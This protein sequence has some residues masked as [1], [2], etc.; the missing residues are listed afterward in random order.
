MCNN[1]LVKVVTRIYRSADFGV[2][3]LK[4]LEAMSIMG[5]IEAGSS[6]DT[7]R[8]NQPMSYNLLRN[9]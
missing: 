1:T 2:T 8:P 5:K 4:S 6:S 3:S 9:N 7:A